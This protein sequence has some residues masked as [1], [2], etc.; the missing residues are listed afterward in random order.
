M[1]RPSPTLSR[2]LLAT[3]APP[4]DQDPG[5]PRVRRYRLARVQAPGRPAGHDRFAHL[6]RSYD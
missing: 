6:R 2:Y 5:A 4:R 3:T 1:T